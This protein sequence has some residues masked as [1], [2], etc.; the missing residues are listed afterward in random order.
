MYFRPNGNKM[1]QKCIE[2]SVLR[3]NRDKMTQNVLDLV[4]YTQTVIKWHKIYTRD[5]FLQNS[6]NLSGTGNTR[7]K[8]S[9]T[10]KSYVPYRTFL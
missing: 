6:Q 3:P 7:L 9:G 2:L 8:T 1:T 10:Q 4:Y 5:K